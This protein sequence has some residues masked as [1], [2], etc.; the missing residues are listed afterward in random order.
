MET[1]MEN[2]KETELLS[3]LYGLLLRNLNEVIIMGIYSNEYG[4]P[5][6]VT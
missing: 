2:K 4:F 3:G 1:E 6:V 5:N